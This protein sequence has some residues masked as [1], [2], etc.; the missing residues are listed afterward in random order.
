MDAAAPLQPH[1][2][3]QFLRDVSA[4]LE[5]Y[6][7]IDLGVIHRVIAKC[8]ARISTRQDFS[9]KRQPSSPAVRMWPRTSRRSPSPS[10]R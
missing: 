5:R 2:S 4:E 3:N 9:T 1:Q 10:S 6:L 8:S 7:E